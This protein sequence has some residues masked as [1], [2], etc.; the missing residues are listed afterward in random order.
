MLPQKFSAAATTIFLS[1]PSLADG[2]P[3]AAVEHSAASA[4]AATAATAT[5]AE[6]GRRTFG[7]ALIR[8]FPGRYRCAAVP[9]AVL[10]PS[11][12]GNETDHRFRGLLTRIIMKTV[13]VVTLDL[14]RGRRLSERDAPGLMAG[15]SLLPGSG[16]PPAAGRGG[17]RCIWDAAGHSPYQMSGPRSGR[18]IASCDEGYAHAFDVLRRA[19]GQRCGHAARGSDRQPALPDPRRRQRG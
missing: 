10:A 17:G 14:A 15:K 6:A 5:A 9:L 13:S 7:T 19:R 11:R 2:V 1:E 8:A 3:D 4:T 16:D 12:R 18:Q